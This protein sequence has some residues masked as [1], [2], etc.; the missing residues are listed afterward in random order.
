ME[1]NERERNM[2]EVKEVEEQ[3]EEEEKKKRKK[4]KKERYIQTKGKEMEESPSFFAREG[5]L[6]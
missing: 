2:E 4:E 1:E 6:P 5:M 3:L